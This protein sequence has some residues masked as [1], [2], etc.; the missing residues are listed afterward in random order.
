MSQTPFP[1]HAVCV[2]CGSTA[3]RDPTHA[4]NAA[5]LG[6]A[7]AEAGVTLIY[8]GGGVGLMG[9]A[10]RAALA[11][12]GRVVGIIPEFLRTPELALAEAELLTVASMHERKAQMFARSDGFVVLPGGVGT[13][14]EAIELL[15]WA[16]LN[17]HRKPIVFLNAGGYWTPLFELIAHTME[18]GFTPGGFRRLWRGVERVEEVLPALNA[19]AVEA[20]RGGEAPLD[21]I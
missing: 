2:F 17:L 19:A 7:L 3:G 13:L 20:A 12:G 15:S 14:E 9:V 4:A 1:M 5:A 6:R 11:G 21:P 16:R 10:A 18:A 8:G